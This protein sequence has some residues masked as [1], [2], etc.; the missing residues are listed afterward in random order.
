[1]EQNLIRTIVDYLDPYFENLLC[2]DQLYEN[3]DDPK[4][5]SRVIALESYKKWAKPCSYQRLLFP[6]SASLRG[7]NS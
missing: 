7:R 6:F 5:L 2:A 4:H 3:N 1:M